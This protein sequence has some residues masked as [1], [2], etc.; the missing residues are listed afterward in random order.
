MLGGKRIA[1]APDIHSLRADAARNLAALPSSLRG[2]EQPAVPYRV[3]ISP[4][5]RELAAQV[6]KKTGKP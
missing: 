6:D 5:L 2:L 3:E 4:A 1:P